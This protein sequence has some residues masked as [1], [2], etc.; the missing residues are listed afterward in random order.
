ME[1][2]SAKLKLQN[3]M[4]YRGYKHIDMYFFTMIQLNRC[5]MS[6]KKS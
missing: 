3:Y 6:T 5:A 1:N 2:Q 4:I